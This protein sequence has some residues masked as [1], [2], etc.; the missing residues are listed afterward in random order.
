MAEMCEWLA[1]PNEFCRAPDTISLFD[2][3]KL[4]WPPTGDERQLWLFKF[5]YDNVFGEAGAAK[6]GIGLVG[7]VT[8]ALGEGESAAR[9]AA[10]V[11]GMHCAWELSLSGDSRAPP[12]PSAEFGRKLLARHNRG[13]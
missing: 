11:Y 3:R 12:E 6:D 5:H 4:F 8:F 10:E 9:T 2:T 13:F 7:S 1:H